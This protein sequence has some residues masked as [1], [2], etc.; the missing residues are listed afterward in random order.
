MPLF[1][2]LIVVT[3]VL[4]IFFKVQILRSKDTLY[5]HFTNAK[6][7]MALGGF[8]SIFG[9]NQYYYYQT[10]LALF[11]CIAFLVLGI[12]QIVYGYKLFKHYRGEMIR[13]S[14]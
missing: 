11:I 2:T 10:Q 14:D 5:M 3:F 6:A 1:I 12:A 8:L 9:M 4:Y 7:R 13:L